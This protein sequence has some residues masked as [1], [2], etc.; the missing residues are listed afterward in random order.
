[1]VPIA[2]IFVGGL[3]VARSSLVGVRPFRTGLVVLGLG[4]MTILGQERG[5]ATGHALEL[6][7]GRLLGH[8]GT[9]I[10]GIFGVAAG[11]L[12][13]TGAS[14]GAMLRHSA[15]AAR[16]TA[17]IALRTVESVRTFTDDPPTRPDAPPVDGEQAY[18]DV[19]SDTPSPPPLLVHQ[20]EEIEEAALPEPSLFDPASTEHAGYRLPD[21]SV[22]RRSR[23]EAKKG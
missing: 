4:V 8:T 1:G 11:A 14:L 18:P 23:S 13:L 15:R 22:L 3:M 2:V 20:L 7:F 19:V 12:L 6:I 5:G 17:T 16:Q 9:T 21:A 10:L